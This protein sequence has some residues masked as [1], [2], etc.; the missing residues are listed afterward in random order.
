[1]KSQPLLLLL[2]CVALGQQPVASSGD[3]RP[4]DQEVGNY[5][6][7][8]SVE[9]GYRFA[10]VG[11]DHD[12]YRASVNYGNGVRLFDGRLRI[13]SLDGKGLID[14]FS[15]RSMGAPSDPYQAHSIRVERNRIFRYEMHYR[16][17]RYHNRLPALWRGE[18]GLLTDRAMQ[19]HDLTLRQGSKFEVLLGFDHNRRR[20]PGFASEGIGDRG[21]GFD[22]RNFLRFRTD[23]RQ[24]N[25]QYR[26]GFSARFTGLALTVIHA[27]DLYEEGGDSI[28]ASNLPAAAGNIQ[29][30]D[31]FN[32]SEPFHGRTPVTTVALRTRDDSRIGVSA[33]YVYSGGYRNSNLIENLSVPNPAAS[34]ST[35]RDTFI[36]GDANR[37]Q[38]SG[39]FTLAVL[40]T[41]RWAITNTTAFHNT[42]I[43]GQAAFL[44]TGLYRNEFVSFEHL[45]IRRLSNATEANFRPVKQFSI[46]GAHRFSTRRIRSREALRFDDFEFGTELKAVGNRIQAG[47][48]G[49]R[50]IPGGGVRASLD[51]EVGR[52]DR[53][54]TPTSERRFHN[55]SG[56][57]RWRRKAF[58]F[59]GF[60]RRR[61][62]DN[63]SDLLSFSSKSRVQGAQAS[64]MV[65]ES[66][67]VLNASYT[68]LELDV[69]AGI[70]NLFDLGE[71]D[72]PERGRSVYGSRVHSMHFGLRAV[73]LKGLTLAAG[74]SLTKDT[75]GRG[76]DALSVE[77]SGFVLGGTTVVSGLPLTYQS[78]RVRVSVL[79]RE[80]L[81]WNLGWQYYGYAERF[82]GSRGYRS[83]IGYSSFAVIF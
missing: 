49:L 78:P 24:R 6:I 7:S 64:W 57:I 22:A 4:T 62:N 40:P 25:K 39:D 16:L 9:V 63:P 14:R 55:E 72:Q 69:S 66:G 45:G 30:V 59:S 36:V 10:E 74:Y 65:P 38:A 75:G 13:D 79:V 71:P 51:L 46:Y 15:L 23:F 1:M 60:V 41:G 34:A 26:A 27:V 81:T 17:N 5:S 83:H 67:L 33:R 8:N 12:L 18:H 68:L 28:D 50:W 2:P 29:P 70:L 80:N 76:L 48:A 77:R 21:D 54:L 20:G 31:T 37:D 42:R 19:T 3:E 58:S 53:P 73:P 32:R 43:E 11:G 35:Y 61:V 52:A 47:A 44:E 82:A 56:R